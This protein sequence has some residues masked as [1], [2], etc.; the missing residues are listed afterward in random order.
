[1]TSSFSPGWIRTPPFAFSRPLYPAGSRFI[2][3]GKIDAAG[4][5]PRAVWYRECGMERGAGEERDE[6]LAARA[7]GGDRIA[8]D[9]LITR[10][11][12]AVYRLCWS[13]TGNHA[14]ADDA[15]QETFVRLF[16]ALPA[17]NSERPFLPWLRKIAWN[18]A[19]SVRR[20][21]RSGVPTVSGGSL[22][23]LPDPAEGP[24]AAAAGKEEKERVAMAVADLPDELRTILVLRTVEGLSYAEIAEAAGIPVGTVMSRLS[25]AR[26]RLLASLGAPAKGGA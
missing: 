11:R 20:D 12:Q 21:G 18:C 5:I 23:D 24:E 1:M 16:R 2:P 10:H 4:I 13:A 8:F 17:Y 19:L 9:T 25:R 3:G 7:A 14:D 6:R 26:A 22:P 15:A